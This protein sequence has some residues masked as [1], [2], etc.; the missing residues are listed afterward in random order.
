MSFLRELLSYIRARRKYV[1]LPLL[2]I[3]VLLGALL[4][5]SKGSVI[6]PFI[7]TLF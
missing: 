2:L 5:L 4:V 7:Y 3:M 1:L 6:A